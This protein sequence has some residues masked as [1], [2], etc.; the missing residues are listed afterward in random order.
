M[1]LSQF[2]NS[3]AETHKQNV[4][5]R[6]NWPMFSTILLCLSFR[7]EFVIIYEKSVVRKNTIKARNESRETYGKLG[8]WTQF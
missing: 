6:T 2:G 7:K 8:C 1:M 4:T 3:E 5:G